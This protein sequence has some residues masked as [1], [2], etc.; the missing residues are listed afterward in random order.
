MAVMYIKL[1]YN[2][3]IKNL[4]Y[5]FISLAPGLPS[6]PNAACWFMGIAT[7]VFTLASVLWTLVLTLLLYS[8]VGRK[9]PI[10]MHWQWHAMCWGVPIFVSFIPL[11]NSTYGPPGGQVS[12]LK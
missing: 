5:I 9:K 1:Q 2:I 12:Y 6:E 11:I 3:M 4:M 7:N 10:S 8:I